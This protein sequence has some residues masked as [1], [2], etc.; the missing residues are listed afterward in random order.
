MP[1][2]ELPRVL[3]AD[4]VALRGLATRARPGEA[5]HVRLT[6]YCLTGTTRRGTPTR[7][8]IVAADTRIF[9]M[10]RHVHLFAAG[11]YLG[12]FRV[13][14]TGS[15]VRGPH[16]DIWTPDCADARRFGARRGVASLVAAGEH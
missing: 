14:D 6:A 9:P 12:R 11:R 15:A 16:I 4:F 5:V 13:E 3:A 10:A 2:L 8:G 7:A 1:R